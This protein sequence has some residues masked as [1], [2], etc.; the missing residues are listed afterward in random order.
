MSEAEASSQQA[1]DHPAGPSA[2][3]PAPRSRVRRFLIGV[4]SAVVMWLVLSAAVL[5]WQPGR[6]WQIGIAL[7]LVAAGL[8]VPK[9][10]G[11]RLLTSAGLLAAMV[12]VFYLP[13]YLLLQQVEFTIRSSDREADKGVY[14]VQT[15][16]GA[17]KADDPGET[18]RNEDAPLFWKL[19]SSDIDG[20]VK[21][22]EGQRVRAGVIG[23]RFADRSIYKNLIS[24]EAIDVASGD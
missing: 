11:V 15:D 21:S 19:N 13:S 17:R 24:V 2:E 8:A 7:A 16:Y 9:G 10:V 23:I 3:A 6:F 5:W 22:L 18:F 20:V 12:S 14:L 4:V 1:P